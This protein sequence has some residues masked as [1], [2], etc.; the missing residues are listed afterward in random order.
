MATTVQGREGV[1][2]PILAKKRRVFTRTLRKVMRE[3]RELSNAEM[4]AMFEDDGDLGTA[5]RRMLLSEEQ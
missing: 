3:E 4:A 2:D 5:M 1:L